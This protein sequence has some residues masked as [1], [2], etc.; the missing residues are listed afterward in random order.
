[1]IYMKPLILAGVLSLIMQSVNAQ[2]IPQ[3]IINTY[4]PKSTV[5]AAVWRDLSYFGKQSVY[6]IEHQPYY[7]PLDFETNLEILSVTS[8]DL[9]ISQN[10]NSDAVR[11]IDM[12]SYQRGFKDAWKLARYP[13]PSQ[14]IHQPSKLKKL[15]HTLAALGYGY[16]RAANPFAPV[17]DGYGIS[18]MNGFGG[19]PTI[20][21]Q[22]S[23]PGAPMQSWMV[24]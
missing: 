16:S 21:Q 12:A 15:V 8:Y 20:I 23:S 7:N 11:N 24:W 6:T 13:E 10:P 5:A 4:Q 18:P 19:Y 2:D 1:M 14:P 22:T 3:S 9:N 17:Y